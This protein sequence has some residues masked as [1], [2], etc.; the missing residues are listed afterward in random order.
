MAADEA[1]MGLDFDLQEGG[2]LGAADGGEGAA[3]GPAAALLP[4]DLVFFDEGGQVGIVAAAGPRPTGLLAAPPG[5]RARG[6]KGRRAGGRD[7][8][9]ALAAEELLL[10]ETQLGFECGDALLEGGFAL[11]GAVVHRLPVTGLPPGLE[12]HGEARANRTGALG[13]GGRRAGR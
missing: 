13:Q 5:V 1:A 12:L 10:A 4:R 2:V 3:A 11:D 8:G 7:A 6:P 9:F